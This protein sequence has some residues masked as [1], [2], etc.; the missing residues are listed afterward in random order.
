M[1][2]VGQPS[3]I[4]LADRPHVE[5]T[6]T[7]KGGRSGSK[8]QLIPSAVFLAD[9]AVA[10]RENDPAFGEIPRFVH[11]RF[12]DGSMADSARVTLPYEG[13]L[14]AVFTQP[15]ESAVRGDVELREVLQ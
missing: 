14:S 4:N 11:W 5:F 12:G 7:V 13:T 8:Y 6:Y 1:R 15:S 10:D 3:L 9:G 2:A